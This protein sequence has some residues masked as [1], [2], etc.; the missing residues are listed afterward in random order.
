MRLFVAVWPPAEV[1]GLLEELIR[2]DHPAVRWTTADQWHV[3]LRFLGE[4]ADPDPVAAALA[5]IGAGGPVPVQVGPTTVVLGGEVLCLPVSGLEALAGA[6]AAVTEGM[7]RPSGPRPFAGHVTLAR[8][9][10][11]RRRGRRTADGEA[12]S[13]LDNGLPGSGR[14]GRACPSPLDDLAGAP[15]SASWVVDR[16]TVA[17]SETRPGGARYR[18]VSGVALEP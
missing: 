3:T 1:V 10:G 8:L 18:V 12:S 4:V 14:S 16:V 5:P 2:P 6:T 7:G 17:V 11:G 15:F 9:R 13:L